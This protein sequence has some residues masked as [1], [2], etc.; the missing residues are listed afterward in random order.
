MKI[1]LKILD[2]RITEQLPQY[3]TLGSAGLDLRACIPTPLLIEPGAT[4]AVEAG[5][6]I[7]IADQR[8]AGLILPRSGLGTK[9]GIVLGNLSGLID[10]DYQGPLVCNLWNRSTTPYTLQPLERMAQ[11]VIFPVQQVSFEC[12]DVF[13]ESARGKGGFGS[14]GQN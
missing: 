3:A 8:Y 10:S 13:P 14:T 4:H 7:Y 1:A 9:H 6:A 12:V 11:L 2:P 5:I